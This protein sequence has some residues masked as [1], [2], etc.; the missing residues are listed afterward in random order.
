[1]IIYLN[2]TILNEWSKSGNNTKNESLS[3]RIQVLEKMCHMM[4]THWA[5]I[6]MTISIEITNLPSDDT[7]IVFSFL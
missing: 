2:L 1:M 6:I 3:V 5:L 7:P 4:K